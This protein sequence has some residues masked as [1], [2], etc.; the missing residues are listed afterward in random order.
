MKGKGGP[1]RCRMRS[2]F[3][4]AGIRSVGLRGGRRGSVT[5]EW[6]A[7]SFLGVLSDDWAVDVFELELETDFGPSWKLVGGWRQN[8]AQVEAVS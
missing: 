7:V 8:H 5:G 1:H 2:A 4:L 6:A 3:W